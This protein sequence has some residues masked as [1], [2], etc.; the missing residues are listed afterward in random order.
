MGE[1]ASVFIYHIVQ[2]VGEFGATFGHEVQLPLQLV[3]TPDI[4][5]INVGYEFTS[6]GLVAGGASISTASIM[7]QKDRPN[8]RITERI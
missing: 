7:R 4:I 5:A 8:P 3:L 2:G 6:S 1:L